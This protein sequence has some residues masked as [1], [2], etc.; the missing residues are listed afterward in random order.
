MVEPLLLD[1][2]IP[3]YD[4][5]IVFS[6]VFRAPPERCFA[7]V[8]DSNLFEIPLFRVL[9][10]AHGLSQRLVEVVRHRRGGVAGALGAADVPAAGHALD[11]LDPTG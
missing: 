8:V 2:F 5:A 1:R 7:T 9:I 6:R 3:E 11:R 10:G 4:L